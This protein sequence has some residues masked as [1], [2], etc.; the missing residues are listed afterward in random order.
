MIPY[1]PLIARLE[2]VADLS[3]R[4]KA[5]VARLYD[6]VR[7]VNAK[8][9]IISEGE[10]P[11]FIHLIVEGWAARYKELPNGSRQIVAFLIPGDFLDLHTTVL[12]QMDHSVV[13]L[14]RCRVAYIPGAR[15]DELT[16]Y[17]DG[18]TKALWWS[19]LVDEAVLR[20][21]V[22]NAGRR[23]A[24]QRIAHVLCEMHVRMNMIGLVSSDKFDL[25]LT[26]EELADAT[27]LTPV[28]TNRTLQRLRREGLIELRGGVLTVLDVAKLRDAGGFDPNYLHI[29]RR[30]SAPR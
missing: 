13:A 2:T 21:W 1:G 30:L 28:H 8:R 22:V 9:D 18:L 3:E 27:A 24:Y 7:S 17:R 4:D 29:K 11:E 5:L 25:P 6:D 15:I 23:D 16:S 19:T 20:S 10:R 12:G 14:T 26:Q